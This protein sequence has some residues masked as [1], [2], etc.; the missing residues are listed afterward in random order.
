MKKILTVLAIV[1]FTINASAQ[2]T[3]TASIESQEKYVVSND[4]KVAS[5]EATAKTKSKSQS[6]GKSCGDGEMAKTNNKEGKKCCAK[7]E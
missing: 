2:Q 1:L 7:K 4:T 3:K 5:T 6:S